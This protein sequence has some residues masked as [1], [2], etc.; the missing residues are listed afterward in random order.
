M[1]RPRGKCSYVY[2]AGREC[3]L[4]EM[5][6]RFGGPVGNRIA[7]ALGQ[8][9]DFIYGEGCANDGPEQF[10]DIATEAGDAVPRFN[11]IPIIF[12]RKGEES[13]ALPYGDVVFEWPAGTPEE[14]EQQQL[15]INQRQFA[16]NNEICGGLF[17]AIIAGGGSINVINQ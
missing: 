15:E 8:G 9:N 17:E 12:V 4:D 6:G 16:I 14:Q 5:G 7:C 13:Q 2:V 3:V 1:D 10:L 11:G